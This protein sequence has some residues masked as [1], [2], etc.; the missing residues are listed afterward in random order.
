MTSQCPYIKGRPMAPHEA[1]TELYELR[2]EKY[3]AELIEQFIQAVGL[4]PTGSLVELNTGEV[5]AV[6]E[7][8]GLRRL[9]PSIILLL[10]KDKEPLPEFV[11]MDLSQMSEEVT[12]AHGLKSGTYGIDMNQLFL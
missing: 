2:G 8:N 3:Q 6:V 9:R 7:V 10:D 5:G 1:I 4:Y 12:V 11:K